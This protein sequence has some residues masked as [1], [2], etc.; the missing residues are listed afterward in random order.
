[1]R[2]LIVCFLL[3]FTIFAFGQKNLVKSADKKFKNKQYE[4]AIE[5]YKTA[6]EENKTSYHILKRLAMVYERLDKT[7]EAERY[8]KELFDAGRN[9]SYDMY[10]YANLLCQNGKFEE[11][12]MWLDKYAVKKSG[13]KKVKVLADKI[14]YIRNL[15]KDS[16]AYE[17]SQP[18]FNT[19]GSEL[20]ACFYKDGIVFSSS[21][22]SGTRADQRLQA[23]NLPFLDLYFAP[24]VSEGVLGKPVEFA[25]NL[26]THF[27][28]GPVAY[29]PIDNLFYITRYA[30]DEAGEDEAED[31]FHL[32]IVVAKEKKGEWDL[33]E[34]FFLNSPNYSVAHPSVSNDGKLIYFASDM[35]GGY[36]GYD[37]YFCYKLETGK[38]S[39]PYNVGPTVNTRRNE[40]FPFIDSRGYL[41]FSSEGHLGLGELDIFV[42]TPEK[43]IFSKV[44]NL[45]YPINSP[46]RD[47]GFILTNNSSRG[48]FSSNRSESKGYYDL[49][50]VKLSFNPVTIKGVAKS[51]TDKTI[52][53]NV[54][55]EITD[56]VGN[57]IGES[58]T[59]EDGS[60]S[61]IIDKVDLIVLSATKDGFSPTKNSVKIDFLRPEDEMNIEVFLKND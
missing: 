14:E 29:D 17:I 59:K 10:M 61:I 26:R 6:Y 34:E 47:I 36:G 3:L 45:G 7:R 15:V 18:S 23:N 50:T 57:K 19:P 4:K 21:S 11:A 55:I 54:V 48:Y 38:W 27:N 32:Q 46:K 12:Q 1:M 58:R 9:V 49:Y 41:Y 25:R 60:Y 56:S 16:T 30:P 53:Q 2:Y 31:V 52:L 20:G 44:R 33:K 24:E 43:G 5:L 40:L 8:M 35:P 39:S 13:E 28:D 37:I 22:L 42:A 51:F